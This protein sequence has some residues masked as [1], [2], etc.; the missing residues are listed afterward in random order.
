MNPN[1][2]CISEGNYST[3]IG[4]NGGNPESPDG[5]RLVYVRKPSLDEALSELWICNTDLTN[6]RKLYDASCGN[7]NSLSAT[8]ID[9]DRVVFRSRENGTNLIYIMDANSGEKLYCIDGKEGHRAEQHKFPFS[10]FDTDDDGTFWLDCDTGEIKK[11]FSAAEMV[12]AITEQGYQPHDKTG[13][14]SH[15][16]LNFSATKVMMRI[17]VTCSGG[18]LLGCY[19][20]RTKKFYFI[21]NKP[22]HQ[23]WYDDDSYIAVAQKHD[24][25]KWMMEESRIN[26]YSITGEI[27]EP[28]G[29][30]GNH[31]DGNANNPL[32][33]GD[34]MYPDELLRILLYKKGDITPLAE[35][36]SQN[37]QFPAWKKQIHSNPSFGTNGKRVYFNRPIADDKTVAVFVDVSPYL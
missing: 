35:L 28:L 25:T 21:P 8:F 15:V 14:L 13:A 18:A 17:S 6:H 27:L 3:L 11:L 29:G 23:L 10:T 12:A 5:T 2:Q 34:S 16:Q 7:H 33:V 19:D 36:D 30:V 31:V 4:M 37:F 20:L 22:V 32:V 24:G 9:N 1:I 26:R